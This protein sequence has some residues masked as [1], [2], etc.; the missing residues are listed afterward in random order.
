MR[1]KNDLKVH[2]LSFNW[3]CPIDQLVSINAHESPDL[4]FSINKI[5][6]KEKCNIKLSAFYQ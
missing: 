5:P 2:V 1:G 4:Q 3:T 6:R